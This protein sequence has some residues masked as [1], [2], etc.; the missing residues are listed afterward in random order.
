MLVPGF[1]GAAGGRAFVFRVARDLVV[2]AREKIE[3]EGRNGVRL[4]VRRRFSISLR[5]MDQSFDQARECE[6]GAGGGVLLILDPRCP[7]V[8]SER[9]RI[10]GFPEIPEGRGLNPVPQIW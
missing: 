8:I 2:L 6:A 4:F 7:S 9:S 3:H 1:H 5:V 10:V